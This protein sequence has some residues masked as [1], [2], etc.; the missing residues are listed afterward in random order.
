[1]TNKATNKT[2]VRVTLDIPVI[3]HKKLKRLAAFYGKSMREIF[4]EFI[5]LG[6][7]KYQECL[8]GHTPNETTKKAIETA[9]TKKAQRQLPR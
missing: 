9:H 1:M 7:E 3:D 4:I 6:L 5:E 8:D 2:K